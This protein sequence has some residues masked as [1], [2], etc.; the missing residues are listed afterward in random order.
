VRVDS[1]GCDSQDAC[2]SISGCG[3]SSCS[4]SSKYIGCFLEAAGVVVVAGL[5]PVVIVLAVFLGNSIEARIHGVSFNV[6]D[7]IVRLKASLN[8]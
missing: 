1:G 4:N 7:V 8:I 5:V 2:N 3:R 6:T